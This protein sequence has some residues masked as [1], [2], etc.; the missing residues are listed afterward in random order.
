MI[1]TTT[2]NV[3]GRRITAYKGIVVGEAIMGANVVRDVFA[4]ITD[5]VGGR[6]GAYESKLQ[7]ARETALSELEGRAVALGANAVVGVDL[8]YEV[9]GQSML[10]VSASGTAVVLD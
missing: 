1:V 5:I 8:D 6:S 9:V 3:E 10:M 4:S 2:P 7:D